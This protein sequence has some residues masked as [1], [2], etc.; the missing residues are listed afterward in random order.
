MSD[1]FIIHRKCGNEIGKLN[2]RAN[3]AFCETCQKWIPFS[4]CYVSV[5]D[6]IEQE[7][8]L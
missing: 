7:I 3:A 6:P 5:W 4:E 1:S 8:E 2:G